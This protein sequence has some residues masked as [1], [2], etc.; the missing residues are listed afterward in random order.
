MTGQPY[1]Q[2]SSLSW[3]AE[4][5]LFD[6]NCF[7]FLVNFEIYVCGLLTLI[8]MHVLNCDVCVL[9]KHEKKKNVLHIV[10]TLKIF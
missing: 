9:T 2:A 1:I 4:S 6:V 5:C 10:N 7:R 8:V 3:C